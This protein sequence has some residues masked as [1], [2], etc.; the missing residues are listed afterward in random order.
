LSAK[1]RAHDP[2][3]AP[4]TPGSSAPA[5]ERPDISIIVACYNAASTLA[6]TLASLHAQTHER[7]EAVCVDDGSTDSTPGILA[8]AAQ[9]DARLRCLRAAH[10]GQP[11]A[12]NFGLRHARAQRVMILDADDLAWPEA[13]ATLLRVSD[14]AGDRTIVAPAL[15]WLS[16]RG[17]PLPLFH[18]PTVPEFSVDGLLRGNRVP[19]MSL[20][21]RPLLGP[22]AF[23]E[24]LKTS[25]DWDLW[26]RLAYEGAACVALRRPLFGYRLHGGSLSHNADQ[27]FESGGRVLERWGPHAHRADAARNVLHRLACAYGAVACASGTNDAIWRYFAKLPPL[28][29]GD[30][31]SSDFAGAIHWAFQFVHGAAGRTWREHADSWLR[32]IEA[33]LA[34][35][36]LAPQAKAILACLRQWPAAPDIDMDHVKRLL[37][38][39]PDARRLVVYGL[40]INGAI[41]LERL[42]LGVGTWSGELV[43]A[44]DHAPSLTFLTQGLRRE[45]PR[46]WK[47][48]PRGTLAVVTPNA[49]ERMRQTLLNAD[50]RPG[51]DFILL[52]GAPAPAGVAST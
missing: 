45:D 33:W 50:G 31:D 13:L 41:L 52:T 21:P 7:W 6:D 36:P 16:E 19:P 4:S 17:Q 8:A 2:P 18:F 10:V 12:K 40:G 11:A 22:S 20:V 49:H 3:A 29:F 14:A 30:D 34:D 44:D 9:S 28:E 35:G 39:R 43:A 32:E 27:L 5:G 51:Q 26:L 1:Q 23:D 37:A 46:R 38:R 24:T 47:T 48:W 15:E 25:I 42:R